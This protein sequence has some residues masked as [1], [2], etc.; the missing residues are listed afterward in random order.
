[1][2][3]SPHWRTLEDLYQAA[4]KISPSARAA[5]L[6][7][8]CPDEV[9][10]REVIS[11]LDAWGAGED[12]LER[13]AIRYFARPLQPGTLLGHYCMEECIGSGG[14]GE[15][16][17]ATDTKLNREVAIK[18]LPPAFA[19]DPTRLARFQREARLLAALNHPNIGQ[20]YGLEESGDVRG[21]VME[22]VHGT[23][24]SMPQPVDSALRCAEQIAGGLDAAHERGI[25][26]R[27]LKPGNIMLTPE[28]V[29]KILDFGL[30]FASGPKLIG[31]GATSPTMSMAATEAGT[32]LGTREYMSPEQ[33][34]GKLVDRRTDIWSF[35]VVLYE[36]L[37][38]IRLFKGETMS[39][40]LTN[41]LTKPIDLAK[42]PDEIPCT[43]RTL[44]CRCLDRDP[45]TRLRDIGEARIALSNPYPEET[46]TGQ[47]PAPA[48]RRL[49]VTAL[50]AAAPV[51]FILAAA[52][53][54]VH[55]GQAPPQAPAI[56]AILPPPQN[57]EFDFGFP[58]S[59]PAISPDG[60]RIVYGAKARGGKVQLW[61]RRMDSPAAQ[62]LPGT[63]DAATPFWSA[64]SRWVAFGQEN[65]IKKVDIQGGVPIVVTDLPSA[66][67]L[68]G[69]T[70][71]HQGVILYGLLSTNPILRIAASGG[72]AV[73]ITPEDGK[74]HRYPWF[75]P[76]GR[77]YL[78]VT[79]QGSEMTVQAASLD[80][81]ETRAKVV[82]RAQSPAMY[83]QGH[84]LFLREHTLA[85]QPFDLKRLE[86]TG[87]PIPVAEGVPTYGAV[88]RIPGFAV[89]QGGLLVYASETSGQ[90]RL[91]WKDRKGRSLGNLGEPQATAV[92]SVELSPDGKRVA[93]VIFNPRA[94]IWIYDAARGIPARFTF[95]PKDDHTPVWSPDGS[96]IYF[97][98]NRNGA[99]NIY[100]KPAN[101]AGGEE[102]VL[103]DSQE[104]TSGSLSPDGKVLLYSRSAERTVFDLW[105]LSGVTAPGDGHRNPRP[106]LQ[107]PATEWRGRLSPDGA[108]LAYESDES[109]ESQVY[110]ASFPGHEGKRQISLTGGICARWRRDGKELFYATPT[111]QLMTVEVAAHNG[112]LEVGRAEK[113]FEGLVTLRSLGATY[114]VSGDGRKFLVVEGGTPSG[115]PLRVVQNWTAT[116]RK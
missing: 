90:S 91:V 84:L 98:S 77:H 86:T 96:L 101:G 112:T 17:R 72:T 76:D 4:L 99:L 52:L 65:K 81:P 108:W 102:L 38:G 6:S 97:S 31:D 8:T 104:K 113:L 48:S 82:T 95:D 13:P 75:L 100:R 39:Q 40:T 71:N 66:L 54:L 114:D 85:A 62:P 80:E 67:A 36:L 44:L 41:V 35:G 109:G 19:N 60:T 105:T 2:S 37:T 30:A 92:D 32:I 74:A 115:G 3:N 107:S 16:Y 28:G 50:A 1:M 61:M 58:Y 10:R 20:I 51:L 93:V 106:F 18:I 59:T 111:G 103:A 46:I 43:V 26:H 9:L 68:R 94:D 110:V 23:T 70:W 33:A 29:V 64:D 63:E 73:P 87:E 11:L 55:Y 88:S 5:F 78:Y 27:D 42:L 7:E 53:A 25:I 21:I 47:R 69:G 15:V 34:A 57:T 22:L 49:T 45:K 89:S 56:H 14:M 24:L 12:L 83:A 116:L 79:A